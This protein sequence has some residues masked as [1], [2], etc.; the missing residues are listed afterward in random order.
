MVVMVEAILQVVETKLMAAVAAC[1]VVASLVLVDS[2]AT[3]GAMHGAILFLPLLELVIFLRLAALP[4]WMRQLA[5][6][7][8]YGGLALYAFSIVG[9]IFVPSHKGIAEWFGAP[10]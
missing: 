6:G 8:A 9:A 10:A 3:L 4:A 2:D 5:T 1:H 7:K